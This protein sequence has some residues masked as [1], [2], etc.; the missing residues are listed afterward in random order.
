MLSF[1]VFNTYYPSYVL[2]HHF[3]IFLPALEQLPAS[4]DIKELV[5]RAKKLEVTGAFFT[6]NL[7]LD[8]K[9]AD[10]EIPS[11]NEAGIL[12][13]D[14]QTYFYSGV[15]SPYITHC[16]F[17]AHDKTGL[18][19]AVVQVRDNEGSFTPG[20]TLRDMGATVSDDYLP[21]GYNFAGVKPLLAIER[22]HLTS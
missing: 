20:I 13:M 7:R 4:K 15:T 17:L 3:D 10:K 14:P 21:I 8:F 1:N 5:G 2:T 11:L 9:K 12:Q 6:E 18:K 16:A 22:K 19:L